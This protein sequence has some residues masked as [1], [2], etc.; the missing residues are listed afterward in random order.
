M[1]FC[2]LSPISE[3]PAATDFRTALFDFFHAKNAECRPNM[4]ILYSDIAPVHINIR[5]T[6]F[7]DSFFITL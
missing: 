1:Q 5:E 6:V 4:G 3:I 2:M 7:A